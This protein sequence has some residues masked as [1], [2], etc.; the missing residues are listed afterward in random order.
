MNRPLAILCLVVALAFAGLGAYAW[1]LEQRLQSAAD[2]VSTLQA[3]LEGYSATLSSLE[4]TQKAQALALAK[5]TESN[6][7]LRQGTETKIR[8]FLAAKIPS[9]Q[10]PEAWAVEQLKGS[11][12]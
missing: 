8:G 3:Q 10:P 11:A 5:A 9:E 7:K 2:K 6:R 4:E 12:W 1:F